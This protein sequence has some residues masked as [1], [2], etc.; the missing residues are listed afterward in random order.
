[1]RYGVSAADAAC[2]YCFASAAA[3]AALAFDGSLEARGFVSLAAQDAM[4]LVQQLQLCQNTTSSMWCTRLPWARGRGQQC[5]HGAVGCSTSSKTQPYGRCSLQR[6]C[7]KS[8]DGT[9]RSA[10]AWSYSYGSCVVH[11]ATAC[12]PERASRE[13]TTERAAGACSPERASRECTTERAAWSLHRACSMDVHHQRAPRS[14]HQE[15]AACSQE[16]AA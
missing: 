15:R 12:S 13:C 14:L 10:T 16:R 5:T 2:Y 4:Q 6:A 7:S 1:M 8:G 11:T 3:A 9:S